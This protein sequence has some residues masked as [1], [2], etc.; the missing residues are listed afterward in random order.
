M[1]LGARLPMGALVALLVRSRPASVFIWAASAISAEL[2][3]LAQLP[4]LRPA[5]RIVLG[6]PGWVGIV[7]ERFL[8]ADLVSA[9]DALL[10]WLGL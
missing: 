4:S 1:V 2:I 3:D 10:G 8:A 7:E 5:H 6:G 9:C